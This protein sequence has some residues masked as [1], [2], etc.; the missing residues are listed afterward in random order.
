MK[1]NAG[2]TVGIVERASDNRSAADLD[3]RLTAGAES[4]QSIVLAPPS[5]DCFFFALPLPVTIDG[6]DH[7]AIRFEL[8][9]HLPLDAESMVIDYIIDESDAQPTAHVLAIGWKPWRKIVDA[10]ESSGK[11]VHAIV[12]KSVMICRTL[13]N[14]SRDK[15]LQTVVVIDDEGIDWLT[16]DGQGI[17][18]WNRITKDET[19]I[20]LHHAATQSDHDRVTIVG[21]S[22]EVAAW[23]TGAGYRVETHPN[24]ALELALQGAAL[25]EKH[26]ESAWPNL[27]RA[28]LAPSD[29]LHAILGSLRI[30]VVAG[31]LLL[32]C[33]V[34]GSWW[35]R[36]R[37]D[38]EIASIRMHQRSAFK[39][40]FPDARVPAA[41]LRRV[42]SEHTK[43]KGS[44]GATSN[45]DL[46]VA[47]PK[48][49]GDLL[50]GIPEGLRFQVDRID[51]SDGNL[52]L[53]VLVVNDTDAG[54]IANALANAGFVVNPPIT[55]QTDSQMFQCQITGRWKHTERLQ[56]P[57][58]T[59]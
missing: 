29:S 4:N 41:L 6:R 36:G 34:L 45:I 42:R 31:A 39:S 19:S 28:E 18:G 46:P 24:A 16:I 12:P 22:A 3:W 37:I 57:E 56:Q 38:S 50:K 5:D 35:R 7:L 15:G 54:K 27:L 58:P 1:G 43:M 20:K 26:P 59:P 30:A 33:V 11:R 2:S 8:E 47:A 10:I 17:R 49:L 14:Q 9:H 44:R 51:I 55:E 52:D 25:Y 32:L 53:D 40:A 23:L 21:R 13:A 48:V